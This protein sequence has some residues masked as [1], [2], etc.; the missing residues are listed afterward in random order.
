MIPLDMGFYGNNVIIAGTSGSYMH[1]VGVRLS[2]NIL[3]PIICN[4]NTFG[5]QKS[6]NRPC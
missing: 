3:V 5:C 1:L 2:F 6:N 4:N